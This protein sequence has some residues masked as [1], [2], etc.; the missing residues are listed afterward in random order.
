MMNHLSTQ[1][2]QLIYSDTGLTIFSFILKIFQDSIY[3]A[4]CASK[5]DEIV[6]KH[7]NDNKHY[8]QDEISDELKNWKITENEY[9]V[10]GS[11]LEEKRKPLKWK[12]EYETDPTKRAEMIALSR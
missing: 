2:F 10:V 5:L 6:K 8:S 7:P 11:S 9:F 4:S 3:F 1:H 12:I